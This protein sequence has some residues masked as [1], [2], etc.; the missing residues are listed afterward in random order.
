MSK[1]NLPVHIA[2]KEDAEELLSIYRPY[3]EKTTAN[4]EFVAPSLEEFQ[5]R[6][7]EYTKLYPWLVWKEEGK[8][9]GYAYGSRHRGREGY[10]WSAE[11]SIYLAPE[12]HGKGIAGPLYQKLLNLMEAQG[13]I[14]VYA[15]ITLPNPGSV[16]FHEKLGFREYLV[17][18]N[19]GN[20]FGQW[21]DILWMIKILGKGYASNPIPPTPRIKN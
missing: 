1:T 8:V 17:Y 18:K 4:M 6:I 19:G 11:V 9:L 2:T 7:S 5:Y 21:H 14:N 13:V 10:Q 3:V 15:V 12:A 20:K 16:R